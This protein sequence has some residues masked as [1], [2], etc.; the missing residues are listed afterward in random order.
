MVVRAYKDGRQ[1]TGLLIGEAN[2]RRYFNKHA[3]SIELRLDDL[4][5]QCTLSPDFWED[6][7]EIHDPRLSLWLEFKS[8]RRPGGEPM[9]LSLDPSGPDAFV[10]CTPLNARFEAFGAD[11]IEAR[12]VQPEPV[13]PHH[14][15]T[16]PEECSVA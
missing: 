3:P 12:R 6:H 4:R 10:V 1:R 13:L 15:A 16:Y 9:L 5:I 14:D 11:I 2:A 8:A 7:P